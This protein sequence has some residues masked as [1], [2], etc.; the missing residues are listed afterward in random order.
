MR[1]HLRKGS[2]RL[3]GSWL[4][5]SCEGAAEEFFYIVPRG[6]FHETFCIL[7]KCAARFFLKIFCDFN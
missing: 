2:V 6:R 4:I 1:F 7:I 3:V 5:F